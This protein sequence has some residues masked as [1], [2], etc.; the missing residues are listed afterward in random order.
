MAGL[1][2]G[3]CCT[4]TDSASGQAP[5]AARPGAGQQ[6]SAAAGPLAAPPVP[7]LADSAKIYTYV[8]QMPQLPGYGGSRVAVAAA[9]RDKLAAAGAG[10]CG[11]SQ[12]YVAF[13][14]TA[15]GAVT[16]AHIVKGT[17]TSCDEA[18]LV[19]VRQLPSFTPGKQNGRRV[20][21]TYTVLV[22]QQPSVKQPEAKANSRQRRG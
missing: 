1:V 3:V 21:V 18:A 16:D 22:S 15:A 19:A 2:A 11:E 17:G 7:L 6:Q 9:I 13:V 20:A 8:E 12:M 5:P 10:S 4:L 14:V